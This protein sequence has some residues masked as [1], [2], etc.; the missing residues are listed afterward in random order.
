[1]ISWTAGVGSKMFCTVV[2]YCCRCPQDVQDGPGSIE[3]CVF[4]TTQ[5]WRSS[6]RLGSSPTVG[7][8]VLGPMSRRF[9]LPINRTI[10]QPIVG[11]WKLAW[12]VVGCFDGPMDSLFV[13]F[14]SSV[15]AVRVNNSAAEEL[16]FQLCRAVSLVAFVGSRWLIAQKKDLDQ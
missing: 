3:S 2:E 13:L 12:T 6:R 15:S 7:V 16:V 9:N 5:Q 10:F 1:M 8:V 11:S 14:A 4:A